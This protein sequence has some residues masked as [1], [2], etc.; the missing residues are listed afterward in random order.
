M[1][2]STWAGGDGATRY[3]VWAWAAAETS[4]PRGVRD[5][6][7]TQLKRLVTERVE[8]WSAPLRTLVDTT[9]P[10]TITT[11]PLRTMPH[12]PEW[13][14][15]RVTLLGDAIHNMTP[16]A[17]TALR[18]ADQLRRSLINAADPHRRRETYETAMR[19]YA[20]R[21]LKLSTRNAT[22][23]ALANRAGS[24]LPAL[25]HKMFGPTLR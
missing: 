23:A 25:P 7:G 12:L 11:V 21:A 16:M 17:N 6:D 20:N 13:T 18:D 9:N 1:F 14:P 19:D 2:M 4:Y 8:D 24:H 5:L 22:N 3:V 15:A 10:S